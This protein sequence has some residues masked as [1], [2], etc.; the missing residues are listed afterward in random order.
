MKNVLR[1]GILL[2]AAYFVYSLFDNTCKLS[3][4]DNEAIGWKYYDTHQKG[5]FGGCIGACRMTSSGGY[6]S[7]AHVL[8]DL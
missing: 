5:P 2:V 1:I 8:E 4:C 6:C 3:G 7:K